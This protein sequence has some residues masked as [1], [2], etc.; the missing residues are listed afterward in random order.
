MRWWLCIL[1]LLLAV[2]TQ[3][4]LMPGTRVVEEHHANPFEIDVSSI[5]NLGDIQV[6]DPSDGINWSFLYLPYPNCTSGT[7][8]ETFI[9]VSKGSSNNIL[10]YLEGGG[11]CSDFYTCGMGLCVDH[12]SC[13]A[14]P[15]ATVT[16][17]NPNETKV[18]ERYRYGIFDRTNPDNPFRDWTIVFVPYSTGD[19][20]WGNRVVK[21]C[22]YNPYN[23]SQ[24]D[25]SINFTVH[26]VGFVNAITA[27]RWA[28]E[29][30]DFD[31]VVIAGSSAGG[32]GTIV[33]SFYAREIFG[34]PILAIDDAGPGL[35][36]NSTA[37]PMFSI[38][39]LKD[40][41]GAYDNLPD[42]AQ[43]FLR[44]R[45]PIFFVDYFL[46]HYPDSRF[47]L[48]ED[49]MD[50]TIGVFFN[51]YTGEQ[52]RDLLLTK[53]CELKHE[54]KKRFFR[55]LPYGTEHTILAKPEFYE[56]SIKKYNVYEWIEDLLK[57]KKK[58]AVEGKGYVKHCPYKHKHKAK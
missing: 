30:G 17:L 16:T 32:Y 2:P 28:A 42:D 29:Q 15:T 51:G 14:T 34:K 8:D 41:W 12:T 54:Q 13:N 44:D 43:D 9:A 37:R 26:H 20:H 11:A 24:V 58:D 57:G 38:E 45:D 6:D 33:H 52:F 48:Y 25:C 56:R 3:A 39:V 23:L 21:Y 18:I 35:N 1:V 27:I 22:Y 53:T 46:D 4:L 7:G 55:Y 40:T 19:V 50:Y 49:Q 10:I 5:G 36:V 47:A 31:K